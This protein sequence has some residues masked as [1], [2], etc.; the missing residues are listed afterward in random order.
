MVEASHRL[1]DFIVNDN[2]NWDSFIWFSPKMTV[3]YKDKQEIRYFFNRLDKQTEVHGKMYKAVFDLNSNDK[4]TSVK[5]YDKDNKPSENA[6][7][8][9]TYQWMDTFR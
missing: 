6:W 7:N 3:E 5:F 4:R 2:N 8:I 1:G 9:P